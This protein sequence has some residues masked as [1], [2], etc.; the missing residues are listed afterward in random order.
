MPEH[1]EPS[2]ISNENEQHWPYLRT[3]SAPVWII[4]S[5]CLFAGIAGF[6]AHYYVNEHSVKTRFFADVL[7]SFAA[8][9]IIITQAVIYSQQRDAMRQQ[10][11]IARIAERAYI[12]IKEVTLQDFELGKQPCL[13]VL[14]LN[15]GHTPAWKVKAPARLTL[16]ESFSNERP[17][18]YEQEG[19]SFQPAGIEREVRYHIPITMNAAWLEAINSG[20]MKIFVNGEVHFE[21]CWRDK[22][23]FPFQLVYNPKTGRIEDYKETSSEPTIGIIP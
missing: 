22:R 5:I 21:D 14:F 6:V 3:V 23:I 10:V 18:M 17:Q 1:Q 15:G 20:A 4:W 11:E 8:L 13:T 9:S 16:S 19:S 7:F 12:G 2:N